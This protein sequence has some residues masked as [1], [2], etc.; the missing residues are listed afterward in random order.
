MN[1][2]AIRAQA[3]YVEPDNEWCGASLKCGHADWRYHNR[4]RYASWWRCGTEICTF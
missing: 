4:N 3:D 1:A 2:A